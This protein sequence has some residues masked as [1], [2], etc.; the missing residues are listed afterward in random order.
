MEFKGE[1]E[2]EPLHSSSSSSDEGEGDH[3]FELPVSEV[4]RRGRRNTALALLVCLSAVAG[5]WSSPA[6][7][8]FDPLGVVAFGY[9][10]GLF[11]FQNTFLEW[12][13]VQPHILLLLVCSLA[14]LAAPAALQAQDL[15]SEL[16]VRITAWVLDAAVIVAG[17]RFMV[18]GPAYCHLEHGDLH[19]KTYVIT[20][21]N[22]G[23]GYETAKTLAAA[24]ATVVFACRSEDKARA[25]MR[26]VLEETDGDVEEEQ[27]HFVKLDTSSFSSV[28]QFA[29]SLKEAGLTPQNLILNA[30]VMLS[31]RSLSVDGLEMTMATN[32]FGHFLLVQLL[33]PEMLECERR[34][35]QPRIVI[36]GSNMSYMH[37]RFD[38]EELD[39]IPNDEGIRKTYM[40]K[41]YELFR[42]YGQSK[43]ANLHFT[44]ELARRLKAKGSKIPVNQIHPGEVLTEVMRDM[45]PVLV[46]L[47]A[48]FRPLAHAFMKSPAQGSFCTLHL[49]L[50]P[51]LATSDGASGAHFVRLS[52]APLSEA[53]RDKAAAGR[54]WDIS[55][56]V[57]S[58]SS[59]V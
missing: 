59:V 17:Y 54:L 25:S 32:H 37:G 4:V 27:L 9:I 11:A 28:R 22:T 6:G 18:R 1:M 39:V 50:D 35:E 13:E 33:L 42:A 49:A 45:N 56:M 52:P 38:F 48:I 30:G 57:T 43:L 24:G 12:P 10:F 53:G 2:R 20:G 5:V 41:P 44:T 29:A 55:E 26:K 3:A 14:A 51:S 34:G 47:N 19:G 46:K 58:Q 15:W 23:I 36:V 31:N 21:C 7:P 16:H 40:R 8:F